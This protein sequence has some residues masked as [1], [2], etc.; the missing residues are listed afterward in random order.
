MHIRIDATALI[1]AFQVSQSSGS[2][3]GGCHPHHS[4]ELEAMTSEQ[5]QDLL[6]ECVDGRYGD[7]AAEIKVCV[8]SIQNTPPGMSP[9]FVLSGLPQSINEN[10][11]FGTRMLE[12]CNSA[13]VKDGNAVV[14][15]TS[16][17]GVSCEVQD[18]KSLTM[19]YLVGK[20]NQLSFP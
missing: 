8:I 14:L 9:Y 19:K 17:D 18:N 2:I 13:A 15:N 16:T 1:K 3:V 7:M 11:D 10:N 12:V 20:S 5:V 4:I 6:K